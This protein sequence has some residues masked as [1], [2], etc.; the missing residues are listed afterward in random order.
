MSAYSLAIMF[1][2]FFHVKYQLDVDKY[3][4]AVLSQASKTLSIPQHYRRICTPY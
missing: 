1:V 3:T 2:N 4:M